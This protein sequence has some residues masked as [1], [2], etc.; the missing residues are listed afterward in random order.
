MPTAY[1][2]PGVYVEEIPSGVRTITGVSTSDTAF[3]DFFSRGPL[4][5]ATRITSMGDFERMFGGLD[6]RSEASYGV[7]QYYLNG[8]S[9]AWI[10]RVASNADSAEVPLNGGSTG[11]TTLT[12]HAANPGLWGDRLRVAVDHNTRDVLLYFNLVVREVAVVNGVEQVVNSETFRNLSMNQSDSRYAPDVVNSVSSLI[13]LTDSGLGEMPASTGTDVIAEPKP[14]DF[15]SLTGG[16]DGDE[17]GSITWNTV[18]PG[19]IQGSESAKTGIFALDTIAPFIFNLMC[20]PAAA[21]LDDGPMG[22]V[23]TACSAYC[24]QKRAFLLMDIPAQKT[25]TPAA[26]TA[27]MKANDTLRDDHAAI[28]FPVLEIPDRLNEYRPR[29]VGSSGSLAG[30]FARTDATRGVW[31]APAGTEA[32]LRGASVLVKITDLEN[33]GLNPIGINTL[34]NFPVYGNVAWGARTLDGADQKASEWK[35]ISVRRTALYIEESLYQ[36][37]KWV[38]FE[39][40]DEPLW[41][42]IRLNCGAFM[43]NLFQQ[44]AFQGTTPKEAYFVK[45]DKETTT[46]NDINLGI[47]NIVVGFAPLKPAEF[48]IIKLEQLAGQ[49]QV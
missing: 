31:K 27:W 46:Q 42:Q 7:Q 8:G 38:V 33:G 22:S 37:L 45:C 49:V 26:M 11:A 47:V 43:R 13:L 20:V 41:A 21:L 15:Q 29:I 2:Y 1:T 48:V 39:P 25:L 40:N 30:V 19:L 35:Y 6:E 44:G 16:D 4:N 17:P 34:R 23:Y 5:E 10:V 36:G 24:R 12:V 18:V 9:V 32:T 3:I 14:G 28:Y